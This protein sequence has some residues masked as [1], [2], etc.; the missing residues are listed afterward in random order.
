MKTLMIHVRTIVPHIDNSQRW[1][2]VTHS[3]GLLGGK[4]EL[5][6]SGG[7]QPLE[8]A[9]CGHSGGLIMYFWDKVK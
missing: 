1:Y 4:D 6:E 2:G 5:R 7:G 8:R 9:D 3:G